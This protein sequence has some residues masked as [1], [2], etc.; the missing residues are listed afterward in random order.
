MVLG[1]SAERGAGRAAVKRF[2]VAGACE[3]AGRL[4]YLTG[5]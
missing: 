2:A 4:P 5:C 1:A 3:S